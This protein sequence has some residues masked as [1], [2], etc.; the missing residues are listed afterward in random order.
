MKK[1]MTKEVVLSPF[2]ETLSDPAE[3][4]RLYCHEGALRQVK[5]RA[6]QARAVEAYMSKASEFPYDGNEAR[7]AY[8]V[9]M[10]IA[11]AAPFNERLALYVPI[12][13]M[14]SEWTEVNRAYM[15]AW[16]KL[17]GHY[18]VRESFNLG[19]IYEA[20]AS[21]G[22]PERVVKCL[23]LLPWLIDDGLITI[24]QLF[25]LMDD[26][27]DDPLFLSCIYDCIQVLE[28]W[29]CCVQR[30]DLEE[31]KRRRDSSDYKR[32][33]QTLLYA[34]NEREAWQCE[35]TR[36]V[37]GMPVCL[38]NVMGPFSANL[39][40]LQAEIKKVLKKLKPGQVAV[41]GGSRAK[42]YSTDDSDFDVYIHDLDELD[43]VDP[44]EAHK[45]FNMFW[46]S[47]DPRIEEKRAA[48]AVKY[49]LLPAD[50][51]FRHECLSRLEAD[52]LQYRLMHKGYPYAYGKDLS[53]ALRKF[54]DI[55]GASA[56][57]DVRYRRVA[58]TLY[59]KYVFIPQM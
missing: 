34:T 51:P 3:F 33:R 17:L 6:D 37:D 7:E 53:K 39:S 21:T 55:D 41:I 48:I 9:L 16:N 52:L 27:A 24:D 18:D 22:Q 19:D 23:H 5:T 12:N 11:N 59:A 8:S 28:E 10:D 1:E 30:K 26:N 54:S 49:M 44:N 58:A 38:Q 20:K 50:S 47:K 29:E 36:G 43:K 40:A 2:I 46:V 35:F 45:I 15:L 13:F 14:S 32:P 25:R 42:G 31:L 56:F 57:Y 4:G